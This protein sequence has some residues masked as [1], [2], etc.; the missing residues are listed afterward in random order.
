[1]NKEKIE[2]LE[3]ELKTMQKTIN[4]GWKLWQRKNI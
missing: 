1:M 3:N 2:K 4:W